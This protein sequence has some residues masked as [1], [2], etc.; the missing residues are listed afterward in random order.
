[1]GKWQATF[2]VG[3][4]GRGL[5]YLV[6]MMM[7]RLYDIISCS[8]FSNQIALT[9]RIFDSHGILAAGPPQP[10]PLQQIMGQA[11]PV[12]AKM[13]QKKRLGFF[14]KQ[15]D[16]GAEDG[17]HAPTLTFNWKDQL[18]SFDHRGVTWLG[19]VSF[20]LLECS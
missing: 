11:S 7:G 19:L 2:S 14:S 13:T 4:V 16:S 1:M 5:E 20:C 17:E 18:C 10:S 3:L 9:L 8:N 6:A 15:P 12:Y